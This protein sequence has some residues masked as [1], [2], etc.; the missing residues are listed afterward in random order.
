MSLPQGLNGTVSSNHPSAA[1]RAG[2]LADAPP[3]KDSADFS[4][5]N[6]PQPGYK[7]LGSTNC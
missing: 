2:V 1:Y 6:Q 4:L 7:A 3:G 5:E